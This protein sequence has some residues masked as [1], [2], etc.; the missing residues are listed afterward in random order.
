MIHP[1][2]FDKVNTDPTKVAMMDN[3]FYEVV[4]VVTHKFIGNKKKIKDNLELFMQ[5][6]D[7]LEP[8]WYGWNSTYNDVAMIQDYFKANKLN[9]FVLERYK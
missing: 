8:R 2:Y 4:Q 9:H 1:F 5:F 6:E 3:E 7:D